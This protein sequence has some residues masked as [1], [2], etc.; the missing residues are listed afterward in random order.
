L[1]IAD[2]PG[3]ASK[4]R[5]RVV[6]VMYRRLACFV[7]F[8][9]VGVGALHGQPFARTKRTFNSHYM[10]INIRTGW[11]IEKSDGQVLTLSHGRYRLSIQPMFTHA[12]G[13]TC[14]R[15]GE[16]AGGL[17]S[18]DA[19]MANV[20]QPAGGWE[21][22]V[23]TSRPLT[24]S[25]TISLGNFYTD[26]SKS[27]NGCTFPRDGHRVWYGSL[28]CGEGSQSEHTIAFY[29]DTKDVDALPRENDPELKRVFTD[30]TAML[31][32]LVLKPPLVVT[33]ISP[34]SAPPGA[35][36]TIFGSGF[37][38]PATS[39][40]VH[41][42]AHPNNP[43]APPIVA[44]DGESLTFVV[45][46]SLDMI[47]CAAGQIEVDEHCVLIPPNHVDVNDCPPRDDRQTNFCGIPMPSGTY[48][49]SVEIDG[50]GIHSKPLSFTVAE[51]QPSPVSI[52]LAYPNML[53]SAGDRVTLRGNG[54]TPSRNVVR[55]GS[56]VVYDISSPDGKSLAFEAPPRP[57]DSR[58]TAYTLELS[59]S[60]SNGQ[61]NTISFGYR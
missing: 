7:L 2:M 19:V 37:K 13:I 9:S 33:K 28:F 35:T 50:T 40:S 20:D 27:N 57:G 10:S 45:P 56:S 5:L 38:P 49:I 23:D 52:S 29:Y 25:K 32:T 3:N 60:N 47:S 48:H 26:S 55:I 41:F 6:D 31:K 12:S 58:R 42:D 14:G 30:V 59:V 21:C 4:I 53:V 11:M 15:F 46:N 34:P 22:S 39:V 16:S 51:P 61:S 54:F 24:V 17:P 36:V 43:M 18:F 8:L 44:A 1:R